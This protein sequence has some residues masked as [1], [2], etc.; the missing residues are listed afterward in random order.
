M[1]AIF[2]A[3]ETTSSF[4]VGLVYLVLSLLYFVSGVSV[5]LIQHPGKPS[6]QNNKSPWQDTLDGFRYVSGSP[7]VGGLI[8]LSILPFLFGLSINTLLPAFNTDIL[9]AGPDTLGLLMTAM[10]IG[11]ILGSLV[12]AKLS[13][14]KKKG[15]WV[16]ITA[17]TWGLAVAGFGTTDQFIVAMLF[18]SLTGFISAINMS[19]NR[20]LVQL[21]VEQSMRGR[22]MSI[23]LMSHGLMPLGVLPIGYIAEEYGIQA[24][25]VVSGLILFGSSLLLGY[26]TKAVRQIDTG[27]LVPDEHIDKPS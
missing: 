19:M 26:L 12:L 27:Y 20:S 7:V 24:G 1:I 18:I 25:L 13:S 8:L 2:A 3:G 11:A 10:G 9:Q 16:I 23:D 14:L 15:Y 17:A 22:I 4:G 21:Q 6:P 5:L